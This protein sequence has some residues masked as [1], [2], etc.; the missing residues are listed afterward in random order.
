MSAETDKI[1]FLQRNGFFD[2]QPTPFV[3]ASGVPDDQTDGEQFQTFIDA[4]VEEYEK[5]NNDGK[6]LH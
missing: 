6:N 3:P 5:K 4:V 2:D 1:S